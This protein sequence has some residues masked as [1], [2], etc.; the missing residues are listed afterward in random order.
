MKKKYSDISFPNI[1]LIDLLEFFKN[2][3]I[4]IKDCFNFGLKNIGKAM[5]KYKFINTTWQDTDNAL[6]AMIKFKEICE[7][8]EKDIPLKRYNE[9]SEIIN[10]NKIDTI[11]L[12]EIIMF[13][14]KR[15]L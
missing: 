4:I 2:E 6:D 14:R 12:T 7:N 3:P 8:N 1:L 9:I 13:L 5:Y 11:V 15:Y 10:Y